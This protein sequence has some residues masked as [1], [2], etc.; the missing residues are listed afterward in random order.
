MEVR[1]LALV[2]FSFLTGETYL[3]TVGRYRVISD[4]VTL[5]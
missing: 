3:E 5:C 1:E 4:R 2:F